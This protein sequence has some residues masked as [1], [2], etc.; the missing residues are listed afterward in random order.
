MEE[1]ASWL[2]FT[3]CLKEIG[4]EMQV[5]PRE[6]QR[7]PREVQVRRLKQCNDVLDSEAYS[8]NEE[9]SEEHLLSLDFILPDDLLERI[10]T[11]LPI[12]SV[13]RAGT[14]CKRWNSITLSRKFMW[15]WSKVPSQKPW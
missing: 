7:R 4:R 1:T 15:Q 11:F 8:D 14:V 13:F 5:G 3:T 12:A 9:C 2:S 10:L 6:V